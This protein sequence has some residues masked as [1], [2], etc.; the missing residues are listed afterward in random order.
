MKPFYGGKIMKNLIVVAIAAVSIAAVAQTNSTI[1]TTTTTSTQPASAT[2]VTPAKKIKK[3]AVKKTATPTAAVK[4]TSTPAAA[5]TA[6]PAS[7]EIGS[8]LGITGEKVATP[9]DI[10]GTSTTTNVDAAS[11]K[12]WKGSISSTPSLDQADAQSIQVLTKAGLSYKITDKLT[13]KAA[14][15]FETLNAGNNMS[16]D[17]RELIERSNFRAAFTDLSISTTGKGIFGSN[18]LPISL[19]YKKISGDA[20]IAQKASYASIDAIID[21]NISVPYTL[22]PK[23]DFSIDTQV[24]HYQNDTAAKSSYRVLAVPTLS[25]N[26]NDVVSIYQGAGLILSMKDNSE[27]RRNYERLNLSTGV[28]ITASKSLSFDL[29]VSQDKAIYVNPNANFDVT[30]FA[31]YQI[32]NASDKTRTF[33]AVSY[34]ATVAYTF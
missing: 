7:T 24:R 10:S 30:P 15:T 23:F 9:S 26:L 17:Q 16:A 20:V 2:V 29:N 13:V 11:T 12:K 34:E 5:P 6:T 3:A 25:Y 31:P 27:L 21:L 19:N 8:A 33:D 18:D 28:A 32:T 22:S 1:T 14:Q 4:K